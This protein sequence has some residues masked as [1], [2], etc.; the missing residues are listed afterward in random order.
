MSP[1]RSALRQWV[2][3]YHP[4]F[5]RFILVGCGIG[6]VVIATAGACGVRKN[7]T[8]SAPLGYYLTTS[9]PRAPYV[10]FCLAGPLG[11]E[12]YERGYR[13]RGVCPDGGVPLLKP[14]LGRPGD[15]VRT[16]PEGIYLN[17]VLIRNSAPHAKD[18]HGRPLPIYPFGTY[19]IGPESVW[20]VSTYTDYS[21]DSRYFGPIPV[22]QI[23]H[24]LRPLWTWD[25]PRL[26][27]LRE[28]GGS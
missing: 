4:R 25:D 5:N 28:S 15:T 26:A 13:E 7:V 11:R 18:R 6:C 10:S 3:R 20:T 8:D 24:R 23:R 22:E 1:W 17:H 21:F 16:T 2:I 14:V 12:S 19:R 9:D 27:S